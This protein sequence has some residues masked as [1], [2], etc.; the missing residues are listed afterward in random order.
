ML[1]LKL[2]WLKLPISFLIYFLF[3][4][5]INV[6]ELEEVVSD[7]FPMM[8]ENIPLQGVNNARLREIFAPYGVR[9]A[10]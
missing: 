5:M 6:D 1:Q 8:V 2:G 9:K 10:K 7:D 4:F 3:I